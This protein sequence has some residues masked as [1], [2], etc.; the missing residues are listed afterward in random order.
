[1]SE[2]KNV[3]QDALVSIIQK[4]QQGIDA[5]V[6]F[7]SEQIPDVIQQL[8]MWKFAQ[9]LVAGTILLLIT[10]L[11][12]YGWKPVVNFCKEDCDNFTGVMYAI[13]ATPVGVGCFA[14]STSWYMTSLQI[15]I[16]PKVYLIEYAASLV[17]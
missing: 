13:F 5:S 16:A 7:L 12:L 2:E 14:A 10:L 6:S 1:M 17:K 11:Y 3:M 15:Y 9:S 4:T 8:L